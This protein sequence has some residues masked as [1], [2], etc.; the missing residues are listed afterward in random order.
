MPLK[1]KVLEEA[2][3]SE[4]KEEKHLLTPSLRPQY[5]HR[6]LVG[7]GTFKNAGA[8]MPISVMSLSKK[9]TVFF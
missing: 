7:T 1:E 8:K 2:D 9:L 5:K 6:S 3:K 4:E